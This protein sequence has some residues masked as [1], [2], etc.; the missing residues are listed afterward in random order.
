[1]PVNKIKQNTTQNIRQK[2]QSNITTDRPL[3]SQVQL[4][5]PTED[6]SDSFARRSPAGKS[7]NRRS[8]K[9]IDATSRASRPMLIPM[10]PS[11]C[12]RERQDVESSPLDIYTSRHQ[13]V[14]TSTMASSPRS[15][16]SANS[17]S[18]GSS[19][20][21]S[22]V[23][24]E[25]QNKPTKL[26]SK[27]YEGCNGVSARS[28]S[29][30]EGSLDEVK[31]KSASLADSDYVYIGPT[32]DD[33]ASYSSIGITEL[34]QIRNDLIHIITSID[35]KPPGWSRFEYLRFG[36]GAHASPSRKILGS[37]PIF[38]RTNSG[39]LASIRH[40][41]IE[42]SSLWL[43]GRNVTRRCDILHIDCNRIR[44]SRTPNE[45]YIDMKD[46][47]QH[48]HI[49]FSRFT[50][51]AQPRAVMSSII[52]IPSVSQFSTKNKNGCDFTNEFVR[53]VNAASDNSIMFDK[54]A[55]IN[56][57]KS[58][59]DNV[60]NY[61]ATVFA[62]C[63]DGKFRATHDSIRMCTCTELNLIEYQF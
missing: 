56:A 60:Q 53:R 6:G 63:S 38:V 17:S 18:S 32:V 30:S 16:T 14:T 52:S 34:N 29:Q 33:G 10:E 9:K 13:S 55:V 40:L 41:V 24:N 20:R 19:K 5:R 43:I 2:N 21:S 46:H 47:N 1:M 25:R 12:H 22:K 44:L 62:S 11:K 48:S 31:S 15:I 57:E 51:A 54:R 4:Q 58:G 36:G 50:R 39:S 59:L 42:G 23:C 35:P 49:D 27:T 7:C 28:G 61:L 45:D 26:K 3:T 8:S 37:V